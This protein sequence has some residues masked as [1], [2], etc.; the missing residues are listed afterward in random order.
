MHEFDSVNNILTKTDT[1]F[2]PGDEQYDSVLF[3]YDSKTQQLFY[4]VQDFHAFLW[5]IHSR[6]YRFA[7]DSTAEGIPANKK[8]DPAV[9][10]DY[11]E[12]GVNTSGVVYGKL[13]IIFRRMRECTVNPAILK[14]IERL[15]A[16]TTAPFNSSDQMIKAFFTGATPEEFIAILNSFEVRI[17]ELTF[18]ILTEHFKNK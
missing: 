1:L 17:K 2:Y 11:F 10:K 18:T 9:L 15:E 13:L 4:E 6:F 3:A 5:D 8:N 16:V 14:R 12:S 7:G